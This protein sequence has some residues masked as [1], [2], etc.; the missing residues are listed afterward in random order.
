MGSIVGGLDLHRKQVTFDWVDTD[1]G[2]HRRGRLA[3]ANRETFRGW[4][5]QFGDRPV[6]LVVEGCTGWR[7]VAEECLAG[8]AVVHVADPAEASVAARGK[9]RRAK[10]DR[11]DAQALRVLA[12]QGR[13]PDSW[14]P[15]WQVLE[16]R[17]KVRLYHDLRADRIRWQQRIH[18]TLF[19]LGAP[20]QH[21]LLSGDR[22]RL[23][24]LEELSPAAAQAVGT[25]LEMI[26]ALDREINSLRHELRG[27][28]ARQPGCRV[29]Q[30][31]YGIGKLT[32]V[33]IWAELG[34]TRR[35][36]SSADA[37][38]HAGLDVTIYSSDN[39]RGRAHLARQGPPLLRW[40]LYEAAMCAS[41]PS[42]PDH[43]YFTQVADRLG[44]KRAALSVAR[45]LA[46]RCHHRLRGLG[47][48]AF[49]EV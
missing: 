38:R 28:A 14:I 48:D 16:V 37:V 3:P 22:G 45:R 23:A 12:E 6:E 30:G 31:E 35:F 2:E 26:D 15:P 25:A 17:A 49:A 21:G 47:D 36:S 27:F 46:R 34:D 13:V 5:A 40:A 1:S 44:S 19:H 24:S 9:K 29:L 20:A 39:K 8:G 18:A 4:L 7:F 42:S 33:V 32:A 41:R 10:T 11:V 43:D